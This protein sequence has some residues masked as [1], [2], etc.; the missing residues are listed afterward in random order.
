M[1]I[2]VTGATGLIGS[3]L[4][5]TLVADG[6]TV[7]RLV[8]A[9]AR[10]ELPA[11]VT[12]VLWNPAEGK[13]D[14][15]QLEGHDG[16]VHLAGE[17]VAERWSDEKK[18]RIRESRSKGTR[19]L[20]ETLARLNRRPRVL[21]SASAIGFYGSH[22]GDE[23]LT[24]ESSP[25]TDFLAEVCREWEAAADPARDAG[26]R[27][28]HL[29]IGIV[30]S[31]EGGALAKLLT[32]FKM[33]VGGRVGSGAQYMSWVAIDD[34]VGIIQHAL[35]DENLAGPVNVVAPHPVTNEEFTRTL[36]RVLGRPTLLPMPEFAVRLAFGE[37]G[38]ALLLGSERILPRR[39]EAAG[40]R[41]AYTELE[42]ALRHVIAK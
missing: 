35:R 33:G 6:H 3:V 29:R 14:G 17:N 39:L 4:V 1:R 5:P 24:E 25:G 7:T 11:G 19:L 22:R 23:I 26:L 2:L 41:F 28:V 31:R 36:G 8:R 32:P 13:V 30:L 42:P 37:M 9:P 20:S 12:D 34:V 15:A 18:R 16:A 27:V 21:V 10:A 38:E 40:Y